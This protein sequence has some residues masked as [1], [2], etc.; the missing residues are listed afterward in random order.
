[1]LCQVPDPA[2]PAPTLVELHVTEPRKLAAIDRKKAIW[3]GLKGLS[4][5]MFGFRSACVLGLVGLASST[6]HGFHMFSCWLCALIRFQQRF[7]VGWQGDMV[8]WWRLCWRADGFIIL[9][10]VVCGTS[11]NIFVVRHGLW[12]QTAT[13]WPGCLVFGWWSIISHG[14]GPLWGL[15][16]GLN[17][18]SGFWNVSANLQVDFEETPKIRVKIVLKIAIPNVQ[19]CHVEAAESS[20]LPEM[21]IHSTVSFSLYYT[22]W[23]KESATKTAW[24]C[25][26]PPTMPRPKG[27]QDRS[28]VVP[29][30]SCFLFDPG[31]HAWHVRM[32]TVLQIFY[33]AC[34]KTFLTLPRFCCFPLPVVLRNF[35]QPV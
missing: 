8:P 12:L 21:H 19:R 20:S 24:A 4:F 28:T 13:L 26:D 27:F 9:L 7:F 3:K 17:R 6:V 23:L 15:N 11:V 34:I 14:A 29:S 10:F 33:F 32:S 1:M 2:A 5:L 31:P 22:C 25:T 30:F 35:S 16:G 18:S